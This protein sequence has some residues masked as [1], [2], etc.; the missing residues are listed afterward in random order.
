[1][2]FRLS[3][4]IALLRFEPE[5]NLVVDNNKMNPKERWNTKRGLYIWKFVESPRSGSGNEFLSLQAP[6]QCSIPI[7]IHLSIST[8]SINPAHRFVKRKYRLYLNLAGKARFA[9][10]SFMNRK[11]RMERKKGL[12]RDQLRKTVFTQAK[13]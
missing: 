4:A 11:V 5:N 8:T 7:W 2:G 12:C 10:E 3:L 13:L 1:M 9:V 6:K